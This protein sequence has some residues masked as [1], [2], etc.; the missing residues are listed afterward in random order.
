MDWVGIKTETTNSCGIWQK[1]TEWQPEGR[2]FD[3]PAKVAVSL[4]QRDWLVSSASH[5]H[6][7]AKGRGAPAQPD[8]TG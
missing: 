7:S 6:S 8:Q 5:F 2:A 1:L 4:Q 3:L